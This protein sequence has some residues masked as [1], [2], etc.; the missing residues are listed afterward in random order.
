MNS[1]NIQQETLAALKIRVAKKIEEI[2]SEVMEMLG[3][4]INEVFEEAS[5]D[6]EYGDLID[7]EAIA[8]DS[9]AAELRA[10]QLRLEREIN[11]SL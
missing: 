7:L 6:V 4:N 5:D 10:E 11:E 3:D 2:T 9:R 8:E 1:E